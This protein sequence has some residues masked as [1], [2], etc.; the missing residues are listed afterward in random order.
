MVL[1]LQSRSFNTDQAG[2]VKV[3]QKKG[4]EF[5]R[6]LEQKARFN[7]KTDRRKIQEQRE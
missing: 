7:E 5:R 6:I 1:N 4:P 2:S 3:K